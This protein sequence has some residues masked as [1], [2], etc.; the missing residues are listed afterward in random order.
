MAKEE[1][2]FG[3]DG[4]AAVFGSAAA[5]VSFGTAGVFTVGAACF[6]LDAFGISKLLEA[7]VGFFSSGT[8]AGFAEP[9]A[10]GELTCFA[11]ADGW[12]ILRLLPFWIF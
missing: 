11:V 5:G 9:L 2:C 12:G 3:T 8:E 6:G 7:A 10:S 1:D 4:E